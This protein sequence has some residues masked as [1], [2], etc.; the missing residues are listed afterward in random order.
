MNLSSFFLSALCI[1]FIQPSYYAKPKVTF[2]MIMKN[3]AGRKL[4]ECLQE[5]AHYIDEAVIIDDNS[6][7]ESV[8]ICHEVFKDIPHTIIHNSESKFCNEVELRKQQWE[9]TIKTNP[10]WILNIDADQIFEIKMRQEIQ[11]L[12]NQNSI[13]VWC[14]RL[15]DFWDENHY[16]D[17]AMWSAHKTHRSFLMRY[18]KDFNYIWKE[19]PQHCGHFPINIYALPCSYSKM[20]LKHYGW[21]KEEDR[22]AKYHRYM[23]LDPGA[24]YGWQAQYDSILDPHPNLTE[25][26]E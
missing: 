24:K 4:R 15:Y 1:F 18:K 23:K 16:R 6:T 22:I 10:E 3:E 11:K 5:V 20:R 13:D 14:F 26:I 25:W 19:T 21:A 12:I 9:E 7:D 17:D 2:S 8:A